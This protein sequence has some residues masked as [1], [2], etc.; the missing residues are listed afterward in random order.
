MQTSSKQEF[1]FLIF[2][3]NL[4]YKAQQVNLIIK[5]RNQS[6]LVWPSSSIVSFHYVE[7]Q[8]VNKHYLSN[9]HVSF[10]I[11]ACHEAHWKQ[12]WLG[13]IRSH[14]QIYDNASYSTQDPT[15]CESSMPL[16]GS[17]SGKKVFGETWSNGFIKQNDVFRD[18]GTNTH[19]FCFS[20]CD[21]IRM[22]ICAHELYPPLL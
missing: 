12:I 19:K 7:V 11:L 4:L 20:V 15:K 16:V 2:N 9:Y 6:G 14:Y 1:P 8:H 22:S 18:N 10:E 5:T 21:T 13:H 17:R 3:P